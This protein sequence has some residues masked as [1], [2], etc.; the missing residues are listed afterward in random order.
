[1]GYYPFDGNLLNECTGKSATMIEQAKDHSDT[2]SADYPAS[3][4]A[5]FTSSNKK[6]GSHALSLK[7]TSAHGAVLLDVAPTPDASGNYAFTISFAIRK[8]D[9][10]LSSSSI[11]SIEP[12]MDIGSVGTAMT[13]ATYYQM[14]RASGGS[15]NRLK[16]DDTIG[17]AQNTSGNINSV[18]NDSSDPWHVLTYVVDGTTLTAYLDGV[19]QPTSTLN[20]LPTG[21]IGVVLAGLLDGQNLEYDIV[22][23]E[24][25][26][27][28]SALGSAD[29]KTLYQTI[30]ESA[31][32][33]EKT[34]MAVNDDGETLGLIN[35]KAV[36]SDTAKAEGWY[37]VNSGSGWD[38]RLPRR[39][40]AGIGII[41]VS[42]SG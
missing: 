31:G 42:L 1:M 16:M 40:Q 27:Y 26:L 38:K 25:Y 39:D 30:H 13:D 34:Y 2:F 12:I 22:L 3:G 36:F 8:L 33:P 29:V 9:T 4:N 20:S 41:H 28:N 21:D 14:Y 5:S 19:S 23:D 24:L 11:T 32:Q 6:G 10:G 18:F 7:N 35:E 15:K 37:Y 17:A